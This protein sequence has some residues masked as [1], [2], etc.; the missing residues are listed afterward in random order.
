MFMS[1]F[2]LFIFSATKHFNKFYFDASNW[3]SLYRHSFANISE[4]WRGHNRD[5]TPGR[6]SL[7]FG[8]GLGK[9][10]ERNTHFD[11]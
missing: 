5:Q 1:T 3:P 11:M 7:A 4:A 10:S 8:P 2:I 9:V 6:L